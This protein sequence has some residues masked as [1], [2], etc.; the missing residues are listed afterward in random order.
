MTPA[1]GCT[2]LIDWLSACMSAPLCVT[3]SLQKVSS[4]QLHNEAAAA[5]DATADGISRARDTGASVLQAA[6]QVPGRALAK[7]E[8]LAAAMQ[9]TPENV[10]LRL[11]ARP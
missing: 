1:R 2:F 5:R 9:E 10:R 7:G 11:S 6:K 8:A 3:A 4:V